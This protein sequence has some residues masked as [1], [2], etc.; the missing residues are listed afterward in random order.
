MEY[1]KSYFQKKQKQVFVNRYDQR[2]KCLEKLVEFQKEMKYR[3]EEYV[4]VS[5]IEGSHKNAWKHLELLTNEYNK[6]YNRCEKIL[7]Y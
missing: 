5:S 1:I 6:E 2:I 7:K 4:N 3:D